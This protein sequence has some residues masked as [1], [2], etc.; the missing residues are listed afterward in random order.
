MANLQPQ[1][2]TIKANISSVDN[3]INANIVNNDNTIKSQLSKVPSATTERKGIM[4][5]ATDNEALEGAD[6]TI[7]ITPHTLKQFVDTNA[8]AINTPYGYNIEMLLDEETY[9][10]TIILK[11]KDG[12][13]LS[14]TTADFPIESIIES[15]RYDNV[16]KTIIF[17]LKNGETIKIPIGDLIGGLQTEITINNKL[18]SDLVDDSNAVNKFVT[19]RDKVIWNAKQDALT[20][21]QLEDIGLGGTSVQPLDIGIVARTNSYSDIDNQPQINDVTLSGNKSSKDL[22]IIY[23]KQFGTINIEIPQGVE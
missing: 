3:V 21:K 17:E 4:R 16:T 5:I 22:G 9:L 2:K 11:D 6:K 15:G 1:E 8:L 23:Y 14:S 12:G 20:N 19:D 13:V 18:S 10:L 7:A